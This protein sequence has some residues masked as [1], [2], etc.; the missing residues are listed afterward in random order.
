M[1]HGHKHTHT[2]TH[3]LRNMEHS[4]EVLALILHN[5]SLFRILQTEH[6]TRTLI[7]ISSSQTCRGSS[8]V[9]LGGHCMRL[10]VPPSLEMFNL[11]TGPRMSHF[12]FPVMLSGFIHDGWYGGWGGS[13][14]S[15]PPEK[16]E[17]AIA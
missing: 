5:Y 15:V 3:S 17:Y 8:G 4:S 7:L 12:V 6:F 16:C 9:A 10:N 14:I 2:H 11:M 1:A 13:H